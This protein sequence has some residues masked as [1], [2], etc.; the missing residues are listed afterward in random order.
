MEGF[1]WSLDEDSSDGDVPSPSLWG[2][3]LS[4]RSIFLA[5]AALTATLWQLRTP[6]ID[7][8][9]SENEHQVCVMWHADSRRIATSSAEAIYGPH[10]SPDSEVLGGTMLGC[11]SDAQFK[12]FFLLN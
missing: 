10:C 5:Y 12:V 7:S 2:F 4:E 9:V 11:S 1:L 6:V 3:H 8:H